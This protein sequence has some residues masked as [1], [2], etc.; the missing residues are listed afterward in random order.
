MAEL[1]KRVWNNSSLTKGT[2]MHVYQACVMSTLL[3]SKEAW[4][5][6]ICHMKKLTASTWDA[7]DAWPYPQRHAVQGAG[8]GVSPSWTSTP[9]LQRCL[10]RRLKNN[11]YRRHQLGKLIWWSPS[12]E[13]CSQK[14]C[15]EGRRE[16]KWVPCRQES[17]K[18]GETQRS[19]ASL[20]L[21]L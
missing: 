19:P 11:R 15:A 17:K 13:P 16:E 14:G 3:Y 10:Q 4:T 8:R 20:T 21:H 2:K 9:T 7:S 18:N 5:T 6:Y 12:L 1:D